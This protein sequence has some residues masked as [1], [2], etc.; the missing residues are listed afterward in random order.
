MNRRSGG[1]SEKSM[2]ARTA[3]VAV[4][5]V[6]GDPIIVVQEPPRPGSTEWITS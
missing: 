1:N 3:A 5:L 4:A 6:G 2:V